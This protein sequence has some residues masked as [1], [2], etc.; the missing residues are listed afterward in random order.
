MVDRVI[1]K[2]RLILYHKEAI[3]KE[4]PLK[5][6]IG[7]R[8]ELV[9]RTNTFYRRMHRRSLFKLYDEQFGYGE[10]TPEELTE[11]ESAIKQMK[12]GGIL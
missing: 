2:A 8:I 7:K 1:A 4:C 5:S 12:I 10:I 3:D 9:E 6:K 11:I